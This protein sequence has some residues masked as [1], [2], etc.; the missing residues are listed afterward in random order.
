MDRNSFCWNLGGFKALG[1]TTGYLT[2]L[3]PHGILLLITFSFPL[4]RGIWR[5]KLTPKMIPKLEREEITPELKQRHWRFC[6]W[7]FYC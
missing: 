2:L 1:T 4:L 7:N 5:R 6:I 3:L